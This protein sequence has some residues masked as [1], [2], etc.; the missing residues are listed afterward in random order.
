MTNDSKHEPFLFLV[1]TL[2][3]T[4]KVTDRDVE[5]MDHCVSQSLH[6]SFC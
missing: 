4:W 1:K 2:K 6:L 5:G 3:T